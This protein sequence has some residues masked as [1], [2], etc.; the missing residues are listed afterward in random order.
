MSRSTATWLGRPQSR[1]SSARWKSGAAVNSPTFESDVLRKTGWALAAGLPF[2][3]AGSAISKSGKVFVTEPDYD[4]RRTQRLFLPRL[5]KGQRAGDRLS[6]RLWRA[7]ALDPVSRRAGDGAHR[8][9]AVIARFSGRRARPYGARHASRLGARDT[10]VAEQG[11]A[12]RR[13]SRRQHRRRFARRR[14]RGDLAASGPASRADR[15]VGSVRRAGPDDR[16][17]GAARPRHA[18]AAVRRPGALGGAEDRARGAEF[19]GMADRAGARGRGRGPHL[20]APRQYEAR[21]AA[22]PDRG[23]D[24]AAVGRA[25]PHRAALLRRQI[26]AARSRAAPKSGSFPAPAISPNSTSPT[27]SPPRSSNGRAD[28]D[29]RSCDE[30]AVARF[31][32]PGEAERLATGFVFTEG[33]LWHPDGFYYFVDVRASRFYRFRPG[34]QPELLRENT[35]EGNGTTFDPQGRLVICE[36]GNRRLTRW[37]ADGQF[38]SSEVLIDRFEGKRLNRP[39]DVV[40]RSDGSIY[41]T[42]PGLARALGRARAGNRRGLPGQAGWLGL[43]DRR[44]RIPERACLLA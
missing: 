33:P 24:P 28:T 31:W 25:G 42:D 37:P 19:A 43:E 11:R 26:R 18:G 38:A 36:G 29:G 5:E 39:N 9:R 34:G 27:R 44:F 8:D 7:A 2:R 14:S 12:R 21:K 35:G 1:T 15:A 17:V 4:N 23:A 20:L 13:R 6:G 32:R 16:S 10:A 22:A 30:R 41:F 40:C 3:L